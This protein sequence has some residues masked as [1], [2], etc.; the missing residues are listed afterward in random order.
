[1]PRDWLQINAPP[2]TP[3]HPL[4]TTAQGGDVLDGVVWGALATSLRLAFIVVSVTVV[5]GARDREFFARILG[6]RWDGRPMRLGRR[7][8]RRSR[9]DPR[10]WSSAARNPAPSFQNI[11]IAIGL[12]AEA[13][14][15]HRGQSS[16][17]KRTSTSM[18]R[19]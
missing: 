11:I 1:M 19:R 7:V 18:P 12:V 16:T 17:S 6:G 8:F 13:A 4:G 14:P 10:S 3:G 15:H 2:G 9:A 5:A